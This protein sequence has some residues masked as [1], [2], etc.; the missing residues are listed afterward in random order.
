MKVFVLEKDTL[1]I[2]AVIFL[3][4]IGM[5]AVGGEF[6]ASV[7]TAAMGK[8]ELPIYSVDTTEKKLALSFDAAWGNED[9]EQLLKLFKK[10]NIKV[11]VFVVGDWV[12]KFPQSV[13]AFYN[14][15]HEIV[16]HSNSHAHMNALSS[17]QIKEEITKCEEKIKA[18]TGT[19]I[20]LFRPPYGEYNDNVIKTAR[21][22]GYATIQWDVDSLDWKELSPQA[23]T[24]RV[25]TRVKNGSICLFHNGLKNTPVALEIILDKLTKDG[26]KFTKVSELIYT[27]NYTIDPSGKQIKN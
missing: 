16:N 13:K 11:T 6:T 26:Y 2:Y 18:V 8:K 20:K 9:T 10:Y 4:I 17:G 14:D 5:F 21:E 27:D 25:I 22:L 15:G 24:E 7:I 23:M 1:M 3:L 19:V 12:D